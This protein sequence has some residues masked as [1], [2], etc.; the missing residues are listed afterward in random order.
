MFLSAQSLDEE[1]VSP[2]PR[3]AE[4]TILLEETPPPEA[5]SPVGGASLFVI[6][7]MLL[8]LVLAALAIYGVIFFL[9][10][11][12]RPAEQRNPHLKLLASLHLGSNRFVYVVSVGSRAWLVGASENGVS[13]IAEVDDQEAVDA[14]RLEDSRKSAETGSRLLDFK[15]MLRRLSGGNFPEPSEGPSVDN[16]RKRRERLRGL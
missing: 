2:D 12:T 7:R 6:L 1:G 14:M 8:V 10:R 15:T 13:L 9:K 16:V 4:R 3:A 11:F 5:A